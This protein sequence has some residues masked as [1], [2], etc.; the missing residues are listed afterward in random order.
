M[1]GSPEVQEK[2]GPP[3][4]GLEAGARHWSIESDEGSDPICMSVKPF[5]KSGS[6]TEGVMRR[7]DQSG[8]GG[9]DA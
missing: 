8:E 6:C 1:E 5:F 3:W 9:E 7:W 2:W 4:L